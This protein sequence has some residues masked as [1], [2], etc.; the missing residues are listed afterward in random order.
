MLKR[1]WTWLLGKTTVDEKVVEAVEETKRR[2]KRVKEETADVIEAVKEV[3]KQ[4]KDV[5][6]A[7][8]GSKRKG[9]K[10]SGKRRPPRKKPTQ[11]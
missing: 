1:F 2:V 8:Q 4:V 5:A 10:P 3:G 7:A 9:R 6:A 11:E